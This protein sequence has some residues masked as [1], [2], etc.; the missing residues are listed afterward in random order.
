MPQFEVFLPRWKAAPIETTSRKRTGELGVLLVERHQ[1]TRDIT[2]ELLKSLGTRNV[3]ACSG[4]EAV[5]A[6]CS[7]GTRVDVVLLDVIFPIERNEALAASLRE[8]AP[9]TSLVISAACPAFAA[10]KATARLKANAFVAKPITRQSLLEALE[11]VCS[12]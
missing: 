12:W 11:S 5:Q 2:L 8:V 9:W 10:L 7:V 4:P 1:A 6:L 3:S